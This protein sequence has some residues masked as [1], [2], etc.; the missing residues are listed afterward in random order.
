ML[1]GIDGKLKYEKLRLL[2]YY[3]YV[4]KDPATL[5]IKYVGICHDP[6]LREKFHLDHKLKKY[7]NIYKWIV[8]LQNRGRRPIFEVIKKFK[9]RELA[10]SMEAVVIKNMTADLLNI[11]HNGQR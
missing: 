1:K 7:G 2:P 6:K 11:Q 4:L 8:E 3:L 9:S 10:Q 5:E